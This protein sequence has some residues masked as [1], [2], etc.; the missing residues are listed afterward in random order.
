MRRN[1]IPVNPQ[2]N[3]YLRNS[4]RLEDPWL[5]GPPLKLSYGTA[6][7]EDGGEGRVKNNHYYYYIMLN[8]DGP[9][10]PGKRII[11]E[12][13]GLASGESVTA[14]TQKAGFQSHYK[15]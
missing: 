9:S 6:V 11:W 13:A 1:S 3:S 7:E 12:R 2:S 14:V 8:I 4:C 15:I 10:G 5:L